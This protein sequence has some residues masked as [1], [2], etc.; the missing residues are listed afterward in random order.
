MGPIYLAWNQSQKITPRSSGSP[1]GPSKSPEL[2]A[3][4]DGEGSLVLQEPEKHSMKGSI[5]CLYLFS[6]VSVLFGVLQ[7]LFECAFYQ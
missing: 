7:G 6:D 5:C 2:T 4:V 1:H 3:A